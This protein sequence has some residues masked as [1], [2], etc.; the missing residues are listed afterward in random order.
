[1]GGGGDVGEG[2][3]KGCLTQDSP[4]QKAMGGDFEVLSLSYAQSQ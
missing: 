2:G 3:Q 1:M 4:S